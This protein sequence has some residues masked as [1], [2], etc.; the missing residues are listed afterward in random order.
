M[1]IFEYR[2]TKCGHVTEFLEKA[3]ARGKHACGQCG[4][5]ATKKAFSTFAAHAQQAAPACPN[6]GSCASE[7]CPMA[8]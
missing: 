4:S 5:A 6:R 2:C 3:G 8:R 7:S 1:P